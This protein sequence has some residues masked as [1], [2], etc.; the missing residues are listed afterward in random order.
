MEDAEE[1]TKMEITVQMEVKN[2]S[3]PGGFEAFMEDE[4]QAAVVKFSQVTKG[5]VL[6]VKIKELP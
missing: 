1:T 6:S 2:E 5:N 3:M 4:L